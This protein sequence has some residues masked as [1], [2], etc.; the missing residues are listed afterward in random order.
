MLGCDQILWFNEGVKTKPPNQADAIHQLTAFSGKPHD[1]YSGA[2][3]VQGDQMVWRHV[4]KVTLQMHALSY[5]YIADYV[6]RN[7]D[8]IRH[9]VGG[10]L[11]EAEGAR[12]FKRIEGDYFNVIGLPLLELLDYLSARGVIAR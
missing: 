10:Y 7:W 8:S 2:V 5:T 9:S 12:L 11:L 1:L 6:Q 4:G 3:L